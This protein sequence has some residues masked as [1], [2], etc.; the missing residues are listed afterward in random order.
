MQPIWIER[1]I[2]TKARLHYEAHRTRV[3]DIAMIG[4]AVVAAIL[5]VSAA[6]GP[7]L[8]ERHNDHGH[9]DHDKVDAGDVLVG[10][11]LAGGLIAAL[12]GHH[13]QPPP[14]ILEDRTP[15]S[16]PREPTPLN[17]RTDADTATDACVVSAEAEGR[18]YA[19]VSQ[20]D[21]VDA[22]DPNDGGWII[23]GKIRLRDD[24]RAG[25]GVRRGFSCRL[26]KDGVE[27]VIVD[28]GSIAAR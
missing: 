14:V 12:S 23:R 15:P 22:I 9:H 1:F 4:R 10:A 3:A 21:S 28:G 13:D 18:R 11:V 8:A 5:L 19:R 25:T 27:G 7:A 20:I 26:G 17:L 24:Y 6:S 2:A 16:P